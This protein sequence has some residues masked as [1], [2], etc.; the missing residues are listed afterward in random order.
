MELNNHLGISTSTNHSLFYV[1]H[2]TKETPPEPKALQPI[3]EQGSENIEDPFYAKV[4][5]LPID[6]AHEGCRRGVL[7]FADRLCFLRDKEG[8]QRFYEHHRRKVTCVAVHPYRQLVC[9]C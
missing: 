3:Q 1:H 9:S 2:Y 7:G 8:P 6:D 5:L 4:S